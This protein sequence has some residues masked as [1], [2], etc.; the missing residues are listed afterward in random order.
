MLSGNALEL[1]DASEMR[2][3]SFLFFLTNMQSAE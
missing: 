2:G 3:K 1:G